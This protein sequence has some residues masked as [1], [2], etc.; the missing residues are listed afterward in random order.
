MEETNDILGEWVMNIEYE[1]KTEIDNVETSESTSNHVCD[2]CWWLDNEGNCH[3]FGCDCTN[4][5]KW[6]PCD[7]D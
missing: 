3:I 1:F 2:N 6:S 7:V 4:G 5:N